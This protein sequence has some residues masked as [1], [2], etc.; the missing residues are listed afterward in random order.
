MVQV[1][2][3]SKLT[4]S[5]LLVV[6]ELKVSRTHPPHSYLCLAQ[7]CRMTWDFSEI[8]FFRHQDKCRLDVK[9]FVV[10]VLGS[11]PAALTSLLVVLGSIH[12]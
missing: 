10:F 9:V 8:L 12:C 1:V 4:E 11:H 6:V 5:G 7:L 2:R 3:V